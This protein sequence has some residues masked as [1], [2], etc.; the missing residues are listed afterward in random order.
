MELEW[1][2]V[3]RRTNY[4]KHGLDFR[5]AEKVFQGIALTAEDNRQDYGEKRFISLGLLE[6]MVVVV[7]Y[8]ERREK[9]RI[10]SMRKANHREKQAYEEKIFFGLEAPPEFE[11]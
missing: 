2:E 11:G 8:T 6:D 9:T 1:D 3:K 4:A 10:I 7:V 5:D